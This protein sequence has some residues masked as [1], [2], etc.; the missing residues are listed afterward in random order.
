MSAHKAKSEVVVQLVRLARKER[1]SYDEFA[2]VCQ[3]ARKKLKLEK[4]SRERQVPELLTAEELNR[5]CKAVR[6]GGQV[7][8]TT[9]RKDG[10]V[11]SNVRV[12]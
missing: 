9:K 12:S 7:P 8:Q 6:D 3:Q 11:H 5:F 2:Y 10:R 4:P 1:L